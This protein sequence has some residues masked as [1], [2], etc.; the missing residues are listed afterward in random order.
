MDN[1]NRFYSSMPSAKH[2]RVAPVTSFLSEPAVA[3]V[4]RRLF[5]QARR[6]AQDDGVEGNVPPLRLR[7]RPNG[8]EQECQPCVEREVNHLG[9]N[10]RHCA[11][12]E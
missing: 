8:F 1:E 2:Q 10:E 5:A 9:A 7:R 6:Q 4:P 12:A 11:D 3:D